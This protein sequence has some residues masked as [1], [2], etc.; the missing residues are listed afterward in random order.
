MSATSKRDRAMRDGVEPV[1]GKDSL[2]VDAHFPSSEPEPIDTMVETFEADAVDVE[3]AIEGAG[4]E[5]QAESI[6]EQDG[7]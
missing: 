4:V 2:K 5:A 7:G 3:V 6:G 1:T